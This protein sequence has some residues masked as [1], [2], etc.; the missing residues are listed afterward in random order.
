MKNNP[1]NECFEFKKF[2]IIS[3]PCNVLMED[4]WYEIADD[5]HFWL[6]WRFSA[7]IKQI[8]EVGIPLYKEIKALEVG[9][10]IGILRNRLESKSKWIIDAIDLNQK[11]LIKAKPGRGRTILYNVFDECDSLLEA[12]DVVILYDVIEHIKDT[13][14]FLN[15]V[16]KHLKV[17]GFLMVDVPALQALFSLYDKVLGHFRRYNIKTLTNEFR[18]LNIKIIDIRYWG[19]FLLPLLILRKIIMFF[20]KKD[21][22]VI[23]QT[24]FK[25]PSIFINKILHVLM[26]VETRFLNK[27]FLGTSLL[28][29]SRKK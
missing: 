19:L 15:S 1:K 8:N 10:G 2:E 4:E 23:T 29:I 16:L 21:N 3:K 12:Y 7:M 22:K 28:M 9:C 20:I 5:S 13:K 17:G 24:G 14:S 26:R 25:P 11:A 18:G 6:E 27:P